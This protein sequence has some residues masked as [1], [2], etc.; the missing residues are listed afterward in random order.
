MNCLRTDECG[1]LFIHMRK[2][3]IVGAIEIRAGIA[4]RESESSQP[5]T[6]YGRI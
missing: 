2:Y 4:R 1:K 3:I 6:Y 5:G